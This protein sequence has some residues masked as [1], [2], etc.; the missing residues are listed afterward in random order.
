MRPSLKRLLLFFFIL[1]SCSIFGL[2]QSREGKKSTS[3]DKPKSVLQ[4]RRSAEIVHKEIIKLLRRAPVLNPRPTDALTDDDF[5]AAARRILRNKDLN[6]VLD[7]IKALE[8]WLLAVGP[9]TGK[10]RSEP[11][12]LSVTFHR[13]VDSSQNWNTTTNSDVSLDPP[14]T[15]VFTCTGP[16]GQTQTQTVSCAS[17]CTVKFNF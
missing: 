4:D 11:Q 8:V 3:T 15:Y 9:V 16:N 17:G 13:I 14:A 10:V 5:V 7:A 6:N 2:A 12:N 1:I